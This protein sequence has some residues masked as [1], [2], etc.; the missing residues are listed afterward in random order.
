M[1]ARVAALALAAAL[2]LGTGVAQEAAD[3]IDSLFEGGDSSVVEEAVTVENPEAAVLEDRGF[4]W[5]GSF[6]ARLGAR[7]AYEDAGAIANDPLNGSENLLASLDTALCFDARPD[8]N[9]RVYGKFIVD[10]PFG[11]TVSVPGG[12]L[13]LDSVKVFELFADWNWDERLFLR[14]GKQTVGWGISRF[15]QCADPLSV[16]IKD[17]ENPEEDL[18]GPLALK[19]SLPVGPHTLYGYVVAKDSYLSGDPASASAS[20]LGYGAK[21]DFLVAVPEN[22]VFGNAEV[23]AGA[24][25]QRM[26]APKGVFGVSTSVGQVQLFSDQVVSWGLDYFRLTDG[27]VPPGIR[28]TEKPAEGLF[29]SATLGFLYV[30]NDWHA[31]LYGEYYYNGPGSLDPDYLSLLAARYGAEQ[32]PTLPPPKTISASDLGAYQLRHNS[33]VSIAFDELFGND[34]FAFS[35]FWQQNWVD[36]SGMAVPRLSFTPFEHFTVS[37]G[38]VAGWGGD[39]S[40]FVLKTSD[41]TSGKPARLTGFIEFTLGSGKF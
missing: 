41:P 5:G 19:L 25:W 10:Y 27:E 4:A 30:N 35:A 13:T 15:Y 37:A 17:P 21:G 24:Y 26:T 38:A 2:R 22:P 20:D 31:T 12:K 6:D 33:S 9:Y 1:K 32:E 29:W 14:I 11:D 28:E 23:T 36:L 40:E 16:G 39:G 8:R 18:E 3:D 34:K 7:L